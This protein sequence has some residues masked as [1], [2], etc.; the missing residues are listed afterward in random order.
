MNRKTKEKLKKTDEPKRGRGGQSRRRKV[1]N[2]SQ[3]E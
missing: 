1:K 3:E 2:K